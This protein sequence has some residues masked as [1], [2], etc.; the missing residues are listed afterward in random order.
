MQLVMFEKYTETVIEF[1]ETVWLVFCVTC[2]C[3]G[4]VQ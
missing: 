3:N 1:L 4:T 2:G